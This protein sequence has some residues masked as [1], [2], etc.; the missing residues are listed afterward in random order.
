MIFLDIY[1]YLGKGNFVRNVQHLPQAV[2]IFD[3]VLLNIILFMYKQF[4]FKKK[5]RASN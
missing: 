5:D 2:S 3:K 1:T 4:K